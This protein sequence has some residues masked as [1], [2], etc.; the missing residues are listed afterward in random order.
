MK[1]LLKCTLSLPSSPQPHILFYL[2]CVSWSH[3][4]D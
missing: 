4:F 3:K 1:G 2:A